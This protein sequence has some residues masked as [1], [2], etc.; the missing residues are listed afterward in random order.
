MFNGL[1]QNIEYENYIK[2]DFIKPIYEID[3]AECLREET[4]KWTCVFS[5][6]VIAQITATW[7]LQKDLRLQY[8]DNKLFDKLD[9]RIKYFK[10]ERQYILI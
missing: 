10:I 8:F 5:M 7:K 1:L 2:S 4:I 6:I 9:F 3:D